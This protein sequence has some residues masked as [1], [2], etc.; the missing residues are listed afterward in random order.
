MR[1]K[2]LL[3]VNVLCF[4]LTPTGRWHRTGHRAPS[5]DIEIAL[6]RRTCS[7]LNIG[8]NTPDSLKI[9]QITAP[10]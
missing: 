7:A 4:P 6:F 9:F 3:Q 5:T 1:N 8:D 10:I 2:P